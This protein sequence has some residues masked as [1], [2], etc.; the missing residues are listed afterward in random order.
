LSCWAQGLINPHTQQ[1]DADFPV[2]RPSLLLVIANGFQS[3][4]VLVWQ[5]TFFE[6]IGSQSTTRANA[7][8]AGRFV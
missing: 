2:F 4:G 6:A 7:K 8:L 5:L 1:L 3:E